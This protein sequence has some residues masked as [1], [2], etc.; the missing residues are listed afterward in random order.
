MYDQIYRYS[1]KFM[2]HGLA[3]IILISEIN[4]R[5]IKSLDMSQ[6]IW[7]SLTDYM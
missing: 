5:F 2:K 7:R 3:E 1:Q 4:D 6:I